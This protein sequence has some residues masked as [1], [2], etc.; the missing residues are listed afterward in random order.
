M[1]GARAVRKETVPRAQAQ[2]E[3]FKAHTA[4]AQC[5]LHAQRGGS[6]CTGRM[7]SA[8]GGDAVRRGDAQSA[9]AARRVRLFC[10]VAAWDAAAERMVD[11]CSEH[12]IMVH[13]ALCTVHGALVHR[14]RCISAESVGAQSTEQSTVLWCT[15]CIAQCMV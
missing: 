7:R 3:G 15:T 14:A 6:L 4:H 9:C 10:W 11:W 13:G 2:C 8:K 1:R 5:G 12:S